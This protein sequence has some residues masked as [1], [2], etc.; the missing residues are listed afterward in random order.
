[1]GRPLL[2]TPYFRLRLKGFVPFFVLFASF[3]VEKRV[4]GFRLLVARSRKMA[5]CP[6]DF[7]QDG[8]CG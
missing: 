8:V 7:A 4:A 2:Q 5:S 1:M 3:V 6:F